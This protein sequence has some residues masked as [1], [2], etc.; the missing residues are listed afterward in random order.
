ME[1]IFTSITNDTKPTTATN[2]GTLEPTVAFSFV[3]REELLVRVHPISTTPTKDSL[4]SDTTTT[5]PTTLSS[6]P[7]TVTTFTASSLRTKA[8][9]IQTTPFKLTTTQ[10]KSTSPSDSTEMF[11]ISASIDD[12]IQPTPWEKIVF[13]VKFKSLEAPPST[14]EKPATSTTANTTPAASIVST[15]IERV[16]NIWNNR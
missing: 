12:K 15:L 13:K 8:T 14:T 6:V 10:F 7:S 9:S 1:N 3:T 11:A 16:R 2:T 4:E 5:K